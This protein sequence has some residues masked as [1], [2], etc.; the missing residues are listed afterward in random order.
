MKKL[1]YIE[2][3]GKLHC[4]ECE[5]PLGSGSLVD[6]IEGDLM[7]CRALQAEESS[8]EKFSAYLLGWRPHL[9]WRRANFQILEHVC[10]L[11]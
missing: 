6:L 8:L 3:D 5:Q 10:V 1:D 9:Y 7:A 11:A 4:G 2:R